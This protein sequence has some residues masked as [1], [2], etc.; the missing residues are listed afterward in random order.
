MLTLCFILE[1]ECM[2]KKKINIDGKTCKEVM[3]AVEKFKMENIKIEM[4][5]NVAYVVVG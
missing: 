3:E 5:N 2:N 4:K 1:R